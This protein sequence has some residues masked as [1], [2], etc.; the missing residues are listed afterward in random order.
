MTHRYDLLRDLKHFAN[1]FDFFLIFKSISRKWLI[2]N[3]FH[4]SVDEDK[5]YLI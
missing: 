2:S 5:L 1:A 3:T 4:G